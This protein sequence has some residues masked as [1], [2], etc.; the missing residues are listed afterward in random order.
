MYHPLAGFVGG[1]GGRLSIVGQSVHAAQP[2]HEYTTNK[3][4]PRTRPSFIRYPIRGWA[5]HRMHAVRMNSA[6]GTGSVL[7]A[8]LDERARRTCFSGFPVAGRNSFRAVHYERLGWQRS[9]AEAGAL[10][11]LPRRALR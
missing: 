8:R 9:K 11:R 3:R 1:L 4:I 6:A 7:E 10:L 5:A 2:V